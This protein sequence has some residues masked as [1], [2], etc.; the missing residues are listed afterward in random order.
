MLFDAIVK[1]TK[2]DWGAL[3][4]EDKEEN[5]IAVKN[6][7]PVLGF[8]KVGNYDIVVIMPKERNKLEVVMKHEL[9]KERIHNPVLYDSKGIRIT[10]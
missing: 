1:F 4:D 9:G 3:S 2:G 6:G 5:N 10:K 8:Y 7:G